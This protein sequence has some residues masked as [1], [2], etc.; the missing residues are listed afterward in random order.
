[1]KTIFLMFLSL[2]CSTHSLSI[3]NSFHFLDLLFLENEKQVEKIGVKPP[4][5]LS[6]T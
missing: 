3:M 1:M 2:C 5:L 6:R 4:I